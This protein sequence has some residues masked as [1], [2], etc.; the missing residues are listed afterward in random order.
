M[1]FIVAQEVKSETKVSKNIYLFD[2]FFILIYFTISLILGIAV[3][4]NLKIA[5]YVFSGVC[6][7]YLTASSRSN[8][9]RRNY[10]SILLFLRRDRDVYL[11][12]PNQSKKRK[13]EERQ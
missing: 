7:L 13:G 2:F 1:Q 6:A 5:F 9:G 8:R 10:E 3:H 4:E 12:V 11:P